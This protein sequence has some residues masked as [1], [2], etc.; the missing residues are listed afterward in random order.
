[1]KKFKE[2]ILG[3]LVVIFAAGLIH[4]LARPERGIPLKVL[5]P[6]TPGPIIVHII[7]EVQNPGVYPLPYDGRTNDAVIAAGGLTEN[8]N[9]I[10]INLAEKIRDGQK[11]I[12]PKKGAVSAGGES[13]S[14]EDQNTEAT[15]LLNLNTAS[16]ADL[17]KLPGIGSEKARQILSYR[18]KN[19]AFTR[20]EEILK[21]TG[22]GDQ[23]FD[24]IK[25]L[26]VA[27]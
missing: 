20:I 10:P 15:A 19:G 12:I 27:E 1:M 26:I 4:W 25:H 6:P 18:E 5:P 14:T 21:V 23:I 11:I 3:G 16:Q 13:L 7:G 24:Q 2:V 8:A 9:T 17:E 22:I